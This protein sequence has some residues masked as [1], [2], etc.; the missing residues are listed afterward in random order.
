[1]ATELAGSSFPEQGHK[2]QLTPEEAALVDRIGV[3]VRLRWIAIGGVAIA[4]LLATRVF[5]IDFS[6]LPVYI[7]CACMVWYNLVLFLQSR[8]LNAE[9]SGSPSP[10]S[11]VSLKQLLLIPKATSPLIEKARAIGNIHIVLDLLA[12]TTLLHFTGGIENPFIFY[13]VFHVIIAGILL[14][15]RVAYFVATSA[16]LLVMLLLGLEYGGVIPHVLLA[17]FASAGLIWK[18]SLR[19]D[20]ISRDHIFW[21]S[22]SL[23]PPACSAL[24]I[25]LPTSREN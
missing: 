11:M 4:A 15:Y 8:S 16:I 12:L 24:P 19:L 1:V 17:G 3:F 22:L 9:A 7:I 5:H 10:P 14:Y 20:C 13:F 25:W 21:V 6:P 23:W 18:G 2:P